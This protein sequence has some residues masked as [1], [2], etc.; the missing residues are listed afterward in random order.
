MSRAVL[1]GIFDGVHQ[2]HQELLKIAK[3]K[4]E[5]VALTFYPHPTSVLAPERTPRELIPLPDRIQY[6]KEHGAKS[7][8]VIEFTREFSDLSPDQ[9]VREVLIEKLKAD[10]VIVGEN[11][12]YGSKAEGHATD[13]KD[14]KSTRLNSSHMSESRMPSSA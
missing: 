12:T 5:V 14:R 13:L 8:D 11:F 7:V 6:L 4:G 2:G 1:I 3:T 10:Q 9:F